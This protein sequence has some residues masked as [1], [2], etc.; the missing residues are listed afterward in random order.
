VFWIRAKSFSNFAKDFVIIYSKLD[1]KA[2]N[3]TSF[4]NQDVLL[5]RTTGL[6]EQTADSWFLI[7]D[8]ADNL[9]EFTWSPDNPKGI[10]VHLPKTGRILLTTRDPRFEGEFAPVNNS[11][12]V[13]VIDNSK[14]R[15]LLTVSNLLP[16]TF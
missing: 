14:A 5:G 3:A 15:M 1:P 6:M 10:D 7:L 12:R 9:D 13:D 8:N 2:G 4:L 16:N 11:L